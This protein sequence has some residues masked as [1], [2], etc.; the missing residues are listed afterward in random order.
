MTKLDYAVVGLYLAGILAV[1]FVFSKKVKSAGDLFAAGGRA[2]WWASGLSAFMTMFSAGTFVVWGGIAYE[3]GLVA[4]SINLCYGL[5]A[6]AAG[7]LLASRWKRLGLDS[8]AEYISLRFGKP[9]LH[10][11]T[12]AMLVFRMVGVAIALY[13]LAKIMV[14]I[15]PLPEGVPFRDLETGNLALHWAILLFGLV[16]VIYTMVGGLWAVL[17]T[18]VLQFIVLS[19][20][21]L[22]VVP[23]I[24][25]NAGGLAG[26][27]ADAPE[28]FMRPTNGEYG[29]LFLAGWVV[30]HFF[31]I[32][33]D[34]AFVQ[35]YLCVE[36]EKA[37]RKGTYLFAILYLVSPVLWFLPPMVFRVI[38]PGLDK[39]QAYI[40]ACQS[41]LPVGMVGLMVA[42]MFS[43][44]ASMVSSQLNVF[45]GVLTQD[46]YKRMVRRSAGERELVAVGRLITGLL[47][48]GLIVIAILVPRMGG[49][50]RVIVMIT[51]LIVTPLLA[52]SVWGLFRR[53]IGFAQIAL[54]LVVCFFAGLVAKYG[55]SKEGFLAG[56]DYFSG[57]AVWVQSH[58]KSTDVLVGVVLPL[59]VLGLLD[60]MTLRQENPGWNRLAN[61]RPE[62]VGA[63]GTKPGRMP[64]FI[65]AGGTTGCAV[66]M[67]GMI[68]FNESGR[69]VLALFACFMMLLGA[70]VAY[71]TNR[72]ASQ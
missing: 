28:G 13:A 51:S 45:A 57:L 21:V 65:V 20:A 59:I 16:V 27:V 38:S 29:W 30:I 67:F 33:A 60:L 58:P 3:R 26:F 24:L 52:P 17:M 55:L 69:G 22:F 1:G 70:F 11:Y 37:A 46:I 4:V 66:L 5:A 41:V 40:L 64:G 31:M 34:W 53:N 8:P 39:E 14:A 50:E 43:A 35:R 54:T 62:P 19:L 7:Y 25:G 18:D 36:D 47:G 44:T 48:C 2:P 56:V 63:A 68:P 12:W 9:V 61:H 15:M 72:R 49:A 71:Q 6:L 23:L 10:L 42:A 32:G